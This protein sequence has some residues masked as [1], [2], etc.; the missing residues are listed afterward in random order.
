[1]RVQQPQPPKQTVSTIYRYDTEGIQNKLG[2]HTFYYE[3][4]TQEAQRTLIHS[5]QP[6][7]TSNANSF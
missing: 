6:E 1:M 2:T 4:E 7:N 3:K 5:H